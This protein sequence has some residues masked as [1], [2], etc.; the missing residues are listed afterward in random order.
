MA[1]TGLRVLEGIHP[2]LLP[3]PIHV[4]T[5]GRFWGR[6]SETNALAPSP[7]AWAICGGGQQDVQHL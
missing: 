4:Q 6:D 5:A 3:P 1:Q 2:S 7:T